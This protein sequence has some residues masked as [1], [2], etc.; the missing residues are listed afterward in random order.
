MV[1]RH[2]ILPARGTAIVN[3]DVHGN[4]RDFRRLERIWREA[5]SVDPETYWLILGDVV[6]GPDQ[7]ARA[8]VPEL[9]DYPDGSMEIV[10][11]IGELTE[12]DPEHVLFVLGN[13]DHGHV[14]GPHPAKFYD[15]EVVALESKLGSAERAV[16]H[17]V[18]GAALLAVAAPCGVLF[19]HGAPNAALVDLREL[20][21]ADLTLSTMSP[22]TKRVLKPL[23]SAYGQPDPVAKEMLANVSR[24]AGLD[25]RVVVHGHDRDERGFFY[26]GETQLCPVIFGATRAN[27]RYVRLDLGARYE[28]AQALR[29]DTEIVRL[30]AQ[31]T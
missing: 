4:A 9:Y 14:G 18:L 22:E 6:H 7:D 13:H 23:L 5:R 28:S 15:D 19:C 17:R 11:R 27:K 24:N 30:Y 8:S 3:T 31:A 21:V 16:L 12:E 25:L 26:E 20:D 29:E 2:A 10:A 1:R